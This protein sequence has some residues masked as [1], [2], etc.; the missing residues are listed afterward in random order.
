MQKVKIIDKLLQEEKTSL[1]RILK[2]IE[3]KFPKANNFEK[4]DEFCIFFKCK[5][6]DCNVYAKY[7]AY[8]GVDNNVYINPKEYA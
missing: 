6:T 2:E 1:M 4:Y 8:I 7:E 5:R 3:K